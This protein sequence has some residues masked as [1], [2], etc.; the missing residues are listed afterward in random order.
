[1]KMDEYYFITNPDEWRNSVKLDFTDIQKFR[2]NEI[3]NGELKMSNDLYQYYYISSNKFIGN[4]EITKSTDDWYYTNIINKTGKPL[5]KNGVYYT[6]GSYKV[7]FLKC[8]Q[9]DGLLKWLDDMLK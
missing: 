4:L 8:D 5:T 2:L 1:M 6:Y 9:W 7:T 3:T